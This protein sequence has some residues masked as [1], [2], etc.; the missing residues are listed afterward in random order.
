[1]KDKPIKTLNDLES[2]TIAVMNLIGN[3]ISKPEAE[4]AIRKAFDEF[5]EEFMKEAERLFSDS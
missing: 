3:E 5:R 2:F 1:M 4:I